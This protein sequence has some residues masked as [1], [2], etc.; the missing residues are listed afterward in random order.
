MF[1]LE[2]AAEFPSN[3]DRVELQ[4]A[5]DRVACQRTWHVVISKAATDAGAVKEL[6]AGHRQLAVDD[7]LMRMASRN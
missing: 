5:F 2:I 6:A 1:E 7:E 4:E 3:L